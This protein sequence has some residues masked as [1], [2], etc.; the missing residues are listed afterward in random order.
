MIAGGTVG[1]SQDWDSLQG[2]KSF[3]AQWLTA[4]INALIIKPHRSWALG[5]KICVVVKDDPTTEANVDKL[6]EL[7]NLGSACLYTLLNKKSYFVSFTMRI[8]HSFLNLK[9]YDV[10]DM[11][12]K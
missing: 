10:Y 2:Q 9:M 8:S 5:S 1:S 11:C 7:G 4:D 6:C 3:I 12:L